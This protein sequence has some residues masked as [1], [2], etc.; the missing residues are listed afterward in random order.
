[1]K[2]T[3][4]NR[5]NRNRGW[6]TLPHIDYLLI[7]SHH[8]GWFLL[9]CMIVFPILLELPLTW[10]LS[11]FLIFITLAL[12]ADYLVHNLV[13][14]HPYGTHRKAYDVTE[15]GPLPHPKPI[16]KELHGKWVEKEP[17]SDTSE[18]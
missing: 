3:P 1:M 7:R 15:A 10:I 9:G 11:S 2:S 17:T 5:Q 12:R 14:Q 4:S 13:R 18:P 8:T 16:V 6:D